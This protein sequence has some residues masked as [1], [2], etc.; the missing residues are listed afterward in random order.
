MDWGAYI[1]LATL[2]IISLCIIY[3]SLS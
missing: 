1:L 3:W 2:I